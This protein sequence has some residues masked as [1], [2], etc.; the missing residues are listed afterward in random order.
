MSPAPA[1]PPTDPSDR[2]DAARHLRCSAPRGG[3][4][5][6][7]GRRSCAATAGW[8]RR[9]CG[10]S[11]CRRPTPRT[12]SSAPGCA[13][14]STTGALR[15]PGHLGGW[16]T[17]TATRECL[18]ILRAHRA[19]V[20]LADVDALPDPDGD[21]EQHVIDADEAAR[22]WNV[23]TLLP[24]RGRAVVRALFAD[25]KTPVRRGGPHDRDPG[26]QPRSDP[27]TGAAPAAAAA[28]RDRRTGRGARGGRPGVLSRAGPLSGPGRARAAE[29]R[30]R[31]HPA[32]D[33][34]LVVDPADVHADGLL[35]DEQPAGDLAVGQPGRRAPRAPRARG[36]S[37]GPGGPPGRRGGADRDRGRRL[38]RVR[39]GSCSS[40][41]ACAASS[42]ISASSGTAPIAAAA[43]SARR[44]ASAPPADR[45]R[46]GEGGLGLAQQRVR[47]GVGL[48]QRRPAPGHLGPGLRVGR[49]VDPRVLRGA[50]ARR[51]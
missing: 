9:R 5:T 24:P 47:R 36:R 4:T 18:G 10:R 48:L 39:R 16:L 51:R 21:V 22:L 14:S 15:D 20:D 12:P 6:G 28:R 23:V 30:R 49:P 40:T 44:S 11:G 37:A 13:S 25:E 29:Q 8:S 1:A 33:A 35:A 31:L 34:E 45:A 2:L 19:V 3:A 7:R 43:A 26:G 32:A 38:G 27:G 50:D 17:T 46:R 41:R 42:R